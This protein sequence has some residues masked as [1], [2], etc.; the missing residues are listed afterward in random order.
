MG[1]REAAKAGEEAWTGGR[2]MGRREAM[3]REAAR[4]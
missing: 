1:R 3:C 4:G 2:V